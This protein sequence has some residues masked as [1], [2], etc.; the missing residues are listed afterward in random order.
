MVRGGCSPRSCP[1]R[2]SMSVKY[3]IGA[4]FEI[5]KCTNPA[6]FFLQHPLLFIKL[7]CRYTR[8][9]PTLLSAY[10]FVTLSNER[11]RGMKRLIR[12]LACLPCSCPYCFPAR[13]S[14]LFVRSFPDVALH[15][16]HRRRCC[17]TRW[18]CWPVNY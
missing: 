15:H 9:D 2:F 1:D 17:A 6:V 12:I 14:F 11:Q 7:R 5:E 8:Y 10:T 3:L 4:I 16:I 13:Q 18:L